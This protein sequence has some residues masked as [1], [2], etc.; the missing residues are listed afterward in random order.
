MDHAVSVPRRLVFMLGIF[1]AA[2]AVADPVGD[3]SANDSTT[4]GSGGSTAA[5]SGGNTAAGSGGST[6]AGSGGSTAAGSGGS[7]AGAGGSAAGAGGSA[8]GT[9]G[10]AAGT[11]GSAAGAGGSTAGTGGS[12]ACALPTDSCTTSGSSG[13]GCSDARVIGRTAASQPSGYTASRTKCSYSN[14]SD[15]G[16]CADDGP[17]QSYR[18]FLRQSESISVTLETKASCGGGGWFATLKI[19]EGGGCEDTSCQTLTACETGVSTTTRA[20]AADQDG[21][22]S[23]VVDS[24]GSENGVYALGVTLTCTAAGCECP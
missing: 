6:A 23:I 1:A 3:V 4:D 18:I 17:D 20:Y 19:Y 16:G 14:D 8:A 7:A 15:S 24:N 11:G 13:R 2:C 5:G 22:V 12:S 9:G 21:W 10:S